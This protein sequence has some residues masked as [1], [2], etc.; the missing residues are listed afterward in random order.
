MLRAHSGFSLLVPTLTV[1]GR[2]SHWFLLLTFWYGFRDR[3][4]Y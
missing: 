4:A 3:D 1:W 2:A